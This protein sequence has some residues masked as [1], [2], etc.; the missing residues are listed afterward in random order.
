MYPEEQA[1]IKEVF[2]FL[3]QITSNQ[4]FPTSTTLSAPHIEA[5][6][7]ILGRWPAAQRF[8]GEYWYIEEF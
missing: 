4:A 2:T 6:V 8:P 3:S 1:L 7:S 5:I